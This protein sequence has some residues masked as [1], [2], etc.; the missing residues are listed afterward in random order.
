MI[1]ESQC[2]DRLSKFG[3]P[4]REKNKTNDPQKPTHTQKKE[5]KTYD[6]KN[7]QHTNRPPHQ[8]A[9]HITYKHT[10]FQRRTMPLPPSPPPPTA[11]QWQQQRLQTQIFVQRGRQRRRRRQKA[12]R[13]Q[14]RHDLSGAGIQ[15]RARQHEGFRR[16]RWVGP[17]LRQH[18][19]GLGL[20]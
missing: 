14:L 18:P 6:T 5:K 13:I 2:A 12:R 4:I 3:I 11:I 8:S 16:R 7:Q 19:L 17:K 15:L 1:R 10:I 20:H 9:T